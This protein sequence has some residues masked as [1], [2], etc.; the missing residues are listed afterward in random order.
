M[1]GSTT[2]RNVYGTGSSFFGNAAGNKAALT[3]GTDLTLVGNLTNYNGELSNATAVGARAIVTRSNSLILGSINGINGA[4][5][6]TNVGIGT[7]APNARLS[8][9]GGGFPNN[10]L[11]SDSNPSATTFDLANTSTGARTWRF[12]AMGSGDAARV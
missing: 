4:T 6:D 12:Q 3:L 5:A 10:L 7:T 8:V 9:F 11:V 2:G 1:F